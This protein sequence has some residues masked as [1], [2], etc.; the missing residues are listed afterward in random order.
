MATTLNQIKAL[1]KEYYA[2]GTHEGAEK[3]WDTR[4][5][6][7]HT[8]SQASAA[9]LKEIGGWHRSVRQWTRDNGHWQPMVSTAKMASEL[10]SDLSRE[11][12]GRVQ[13]VRDSEGRVLAA[14]KAT[15]DEKNKELH[16]DTLTLSPEVI[17]G[18]VAGRTAHLA[19]LGEFT[20][21]AA[22]K[23]YGLS[24]PASAELFS[25][26]GMNK[27]GDKYKWTPEVTAKM[28]EL[29]NK[30]ML[31]ES[32]LP[33][34]TDY[35][36]KL[37]DVHKSLRK[38]DHKLM[39]V[40]HKEVSAGGVG[41]GR[42]KEV[43]V[44][45][46]IKN[47]PW[48]KQTDVERLA[49][50]RKDPR[51]QNL[52]QAGGP[53]SGVYDHKKRRQ[54]LKEF[55]KQTK[56]QVKEQNKE[57]KSVDK[58]KAKEARHDTKHTLKNLGFKKDTRISE[59]SGKEQHFFVKQEGLWRSA[60]V[61]RVFVGKAGNWEHH[62]YKFD[63]K[64]K[65]GIT[66]KT[67]GVDSAS[68][69][70]H[71]GGIGSGEFKPSWFKS[72]KQK[73]DNS[74]S[75]SSSSMEI[76]EVLRNN[77]WGYVGREDAFLIFA[78]KAHPKIKIHANIETEIWTTDLSQGE[79]AKNLAFYL[80][81]LDKKPIPAPTEPR[82]IAALNKLDKQEI[83]AAAEEFAKLQIKNFLLF[84]EHKDVTAY[85][86]A[87]AGSK[88]R[89]ARKLLQAVKATSE[90]PRGL[91]SDQ[92]AINR[93]PVEFFIR[94]P[95]E[96]I[97]PQRT[98]RYGHSGN[99][100]VEYPVI[101]ITS[102]GKRFAIDGNHR[103]N[104]AL[105]LGVKFQ[106]KVI[107]LG[108]FALAAGGQGSGR[109]KDYDL[110]DKASAV[111]W[112]KN[113]IAELKKKGWD[114]QQIHDHVL[115]EVGKKGNIGSQ[116]HVQKELK[117]QF[118]QPKERKA[119]K[120]DGVIIDDE[121]LK[122]VAKKKK[123]GNH[124]LNIVVKSPQ[125]KEPVKKQRVLTPDEM[126]LQQLQKKLKKIAHRKV[127]KHLQNLIDQDKMSG[128]GVGSGRHSSY[129]SAKKKGTIKQ[130]PG[131]H[132]L[133][134][135]K[136]N[137]TITREHEGKDWF[138]TS[139]IHES[140]ES[141]EKLAKKHN[142]SKLIYAGGPGSGRKPGFGHHY[143]VPPVLSKKQKEALAKYKPTRAFEHAQSDIGER[144]VREAVKGKATP[145]H[146]P[147]DVMIGK[148]GIE[149][150]TLVS[151]KEA[152]GVG[153]YSRHPRAFI[154]SEALARKYAWAQKT[155]N[156]LHTVVVDLRAVKNGKPNAVYHYPGVAPSRSIAKMTMTD[157]KG[158]KALIK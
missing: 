19:V 84:E 60:V 150:K 95:D 64:N 89:I 9:D 157:L 100:G 48:A 45:K 46:I 61:H 4:G 121:D 30:K 130:Y 136:Y 41:S 25:R 82:I 1:Q 34:I 108:K 20:K 147:V 37:K 124:T 26:L 131:N 51:Q 27:I 85:R 111:A 114:K 43:D 115:S 63:D 127:K 113:L 83:T 94:R 149:V 117:I 62:T 72:S 39:V 68:L 6:G 58:D 24:G 99:G 65:F 88:K 146:H 80:D 96:I 120:Y 28:K 69:G 57:K 44:Q 152:A 110:K 158:L 93:K 17:L 18:D 32:T 154:D 3:G 31:A 16:V 38:N 101:G 22:D 141:A 155:G 102:D 134:P 79:G 97:T 36:A 35:A 59:T 10:D 123:V 119:G 138:V 87:I 140:K 40:S 14:G 103:I 143:F 142:V 8:A 105:L 86:L 29:F 53:G 7:K 50:A 137:L 81:K 78:N 132:E 42:K 148:H 106:A 144:L 98:M 71:L 135:N 151:Q 74:N 5:R 15:V 21:W 75:V 92:L 122:A 109:H 67:K 56:Q 66:S 70:K 77:G 129:V 118:T 55:I 47:K 52:F 112:A 107:D 128:G 90:S 104:A 116:L 2:V 11:I 125:A 126:E 76:R 133:Y 156:K 153:M 23:G 49:I 91:L 54:Q 145:N 139:T 73:Q 13:V 12:A 33:Q